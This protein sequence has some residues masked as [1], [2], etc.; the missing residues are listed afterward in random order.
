MLHIKKMTAFVSL[1]FVVVS[2]A[3][4]QIRYGATVGVDVSNFLYKVPADDVTHL[5]QIFHGGALVEFGK[6]EGFAFGTG[7]I[8]T[9]KGMKQSYEVGNYLERHTTNVYYLQ[10]PAKVIL[11]GKGVYGAIGPYA[12]YGLFGKERTKYKPLSDEVDERIQGSRNLKFG[13]EL[14]DDF[15][16]FELGLNVEFGVETKYG[17]R[18][19]VQYQNAFTDNRPSDYKDLK[20]ASKRYSYSV[21]MSVGYMFNYQAN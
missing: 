19:M 10:V 20:G 16:P 5:T 9:G 8:L 17:L 12:S 15:N 7:L 14:S 18:F 6:Q 11:H 3:F 4:G 1:L 2:M 13:N 21:G